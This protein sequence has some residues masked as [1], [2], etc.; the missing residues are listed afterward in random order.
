MKS[1][2]LK[3]SIITFI[4]LIMLTIIGLTG[5][6]SYLLF[7]YPEVD[8]PASCG[9]V[10]Y[11]W[12]VEC[13]TEIPVL[14]LFDLPYPTDYEQSIRNKQ[15]LNGTWR[16]K[17]DQDEVGEEQEWNLLTDYDDSWMET[18]IPSTYNTQESDYR[19][20]LGVVWFMKKFKNE[21]SASE[22]N[23][24][25]LCFRGV[26]LRSKIWLNGIL[27]GE[28]EGGYTPFYFNINEYLN[29]DGE[30]TLIVKTDNR[31]TYSSIPPM[32]RD[33]N[34]PGWWTYGGIY[35]DVYIEQIPN[36]YIF[37]AR[38]SSS[39]LDSNLADFTFNILTHHLEDIPA[40]ENYI[41]VE[42]TDM[43]DNKIYYS[44]T[45]LNPPM[46]K[47]SVNNI[48]IKIE[49]PILYS[50]NNPN[51]YNIRVS[52][53][54]EGIGENARDEIVDSISFKTGIRSIEVD[55]TAVLLNNEDLLIKGIAKH[56]DTP[57]LGAT[58]S[59][60]IISRDLNLIK[61]MNANFIRMAHYPHCAEEMNMARD[62]GLLMSEEIGYYQVGV[63]WTQWWQEETGLSAMPLS[64]FGLKQLHDK[65][66]LLNAQRELIEMVERDINN[67]G[68][69]L[70][71][72][73]NES[74]SLWEEAGMVYG[75]MREVVR[76]FDD[77][78]PVTCTELTY[79][80]PIL[81][82]ARTSG[83]YM[84]II[85]INSYFGWYYGKP[86]DIGPHVDRYHAL[87][88]NKP[89]I[90]TEFGS[91]AGYG[92]TEEDGEYRAE[93]VPPGRTYSEEYQEYVIS[94]YID[95]LKE[96]DF[97]AG[98]TPWVFADFLCPWF[99]NNP[100][101]M[102]NNKGVMSKD[103]KPKDSYE[104]LKQTYGEL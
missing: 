56:E 95:I 87:Y 10:G 38:V 73:S 86:E 23:F 31:P 45:M 26:L 4:S 91:G 101:P 97:I 53:L 22:E 104:Y 18:N 14:W 63:G 76:A 103:R 90:V 11:N 67:P 52:I 62:M 30:N 15:S 60:D 24:L 5:F 71:M 102:Y 47:I 94:T 20:Y 7:I 66:L 2:A 80:I 65:E 6:T 82:D 89:I 58:Q 36:H 74:Y 35:R 75:W 12:K 25:R 41:T 27:I 34:N 70:W 69:I 54:K 19:D 51:T 55:G 57:S 42:I 17:F 64:T 83:E 68:I 48:S 1:K 50:H 96:K 92:R 16:M 40:G 13:Y 43:D 29:P 100:V 44:K 21:L 39:I 77:T 46:D 32:I 28:R 93:R 61:E 84:D 88:P 98:F 85:S 81:D 3:W 49:N 72:V 37:K 33:D 9:A 8:L 59:T 99:P 78:R 79:D